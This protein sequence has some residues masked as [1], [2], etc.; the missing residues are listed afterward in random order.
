MVLPVD[1][2]IQMQRFVTDMIGSLSEVYLASLNR[3]H[4]AVMVEHCYR[5]GDMYYIHGSNVFNA[6]HTTDNVGMIPRSFKRAKLLDKDLVDKHLVW[7]NDYS[8]FQREQERILQTVRSICIRAKDWQD[9]R[10]MFPEY[11]IGEFLL[12]HWDISSLVRTRP[13]LY[14]GP[15]DG[16]DYPMNLAARACW[17]MNLMNMYGQIGGML[18]G[19]VGYKFL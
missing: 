13:D 6:D 5:T 8:D 11:V 15:M 17:P 19:Y 2:N 9:I 1:K 18:A 16:P 12:N 14:L 7:W 4:E 3:Q 10:D